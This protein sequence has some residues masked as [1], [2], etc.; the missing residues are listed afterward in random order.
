MAFSVALTIFCL[1][2]VYRVSALPPFGIWLHCF[3]HN[4]T[5]GRDERGELVTSHIA[6]LFGIALPVWLSVALNPGLLLESYWGQSPQ[7]KHQM[8]LT[9]ARSLAPY[10]GVLALGLGDSAA[11]VIGRNFGRM[12][13]SGS[14]RTVEGTIS[15]FVSTLCGALLLS[16][17]GIVDHLNAV[18]TLRAITSAALLEASCLQNDNLIIPPVFWILLQQKS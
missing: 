15:Y 5:V 3:L 6:L 8:L 2:E 11:S 1:L 16:R 7:M 12:R 13:W 18:Q 17:L 14:K 9:I 4:F 10:A